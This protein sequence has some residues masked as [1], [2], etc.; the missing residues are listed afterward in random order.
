MIELKNVSKKFGDKIAV[1]NINLIVKPGHIMGLIGQNGAGKTTTFR[2][3]LNFIEPTTGSINWDGNPIDDLMRTRIGFLP[4]E[5]GLYQKL[6]I[7]EQVL[8]FAEL[9]GMKRSE[10]RLELQDWM[11]RLE[12]V[13]TIHDKVQKLSKG[14]AQKI[15]LISTLIFNPEFVILDEPFTGMD[16][17]NTEIVMQEIKQLKQRGATIIFSSH[18]MSGVEQLSDELTM[19]R[20][21]RTVLQGSVANIRESFGRTEIYIESD[22]LDDQLK[23][24]DGVKSIERRGIGRQ[25]HLSDPLAG[26]AIF[27]LVS[28]DGYVSAF[29]QQAPT[30]DDIFRR[31]ATEGKQ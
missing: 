12:V 11:K 18:N 13:G 8:Y 15:Q 4:E 19:L 20:A 1:N 28:A 9:H 10:A 24:I 5:R 6:T 29:A 7:E 2:M 27:K 26:H 23:S 16:P 25:I 31:E 3:L 30:L 14:N 21:G 22:V 17:V